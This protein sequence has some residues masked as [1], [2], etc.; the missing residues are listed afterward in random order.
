MSRVFGRKGGTAR[1]GVSEMPVDDRII[2][3]I[4]K[5]NGRSRIDGSLQ[6]ET[7]GGLERVERSLRKRRKKRAKGSTLEIAHRRNHID[8]DASPN[9][10]RSPVWQV[11]EATVTAIDTGSTT[12]A[13]TG[14]ND[15][16]PLA[17]EGQLEDFDRSVNEAVF[18]VDERT[19]SNSRGS[20]DTSANL[21]LSKIANPK[22]EIGTSPAFEGSNNK[23]LLPTDVASPNSSCQG[24][25]LI[26]VKEELSDDRLGSN[27]R[28]LLVPVS[29]NLYVLKSIRE[30]PRIDG[31]VTKLSGD[32]VNGTSATLFKAHI[33]HEV[34]DAGR[35]YLPD[36]NANYLYPTPHLRVPE[37]TENPMGH[38]ASYPVFLYPGVAF[39]TRANSIGTTPETSDGQVVSPLPDYANVSLV[40][41]NSRGGVNS[42]DSS[43]LLPSSFIPNYEVSPRG[44]ADDD[45]QPGT[46]SAK[47]DEV[48]LLQRDSGDHEDSSSEFGIE[49]T[50]ADFRDIFGVPDDNVYT[51]ATFETKYLTGDGEAFDVSGN[52]GDDFKFSTAG[53]EDAPVTGF[54]DNIS[55]RY[56]AASDANGGGTLL[57]NVA[58][59]SDTENVPNGEDKDSRECG[60]S[61]SGEYKTSTY[62]GDFDY[63][64]K[65]ISEASLRNTTDVDSF[66]GEDYVT[67]AS[68]LPSTDERPLKKAQSDVENSRVLLMAIK[69]L[70]S[71]LQKLLSAVKLVNR[72]LG[73]VQ[74]RLCDKKNVV[75]A[76]R[77]S[78]A[79]NITGL[80]NRVDRYDSDLF[81]ESFD[82]QPLDERRVKTEDGSVAE[83]DMKIRRRINGLFLN[84]L[85]TPF[86]KR[87]S[88]AEVQDDRGK[89]LKKRKLN[90][91]ES[92][93]SGNVERRGLPH[94]R[95]NRNPKSVTKNDEVRVKP[96]QRLIAGLKRTKR[97][98]TSIIRSSRL[99]ESS[100]SSEN[101]FAGGRERSRRRNNQTGR[102]IISS[103]STPSDI[104]MN[105]NSA[106]RFLSDRRDLQRDVKSSEM[107]GSDKEKKTPPIDKQ[108]RKEETAYA[109][110]L[111]LLSK[112]E[113][114]HVEYATDMW[115][116]E[117]VTESLPSL[118]FTTTESLSALTFLPYFAEES[119]TT[120]AER[121]EA[122][123]TTAVTGIPLRI[124]TTENFT[125]ESAILLTPFLEG[126]TDITLKIEIP[127]A[128]ETSVEETPV[129]IKTE[130][131]EETVESTSTEIMESL[132]VETNTSLYTSSTVSLFKTIGAELT[133]ETTSP[134]PPAVPV[135]T[136]LTTDFRTATS[137]STLGGT[138]YN[139]TAIASSPTVSERMEAISSTTEMAITTLTPEDE[140]PVTQIEKTITAEETATEIPTTI[141]TAT[142]EI[143]IS[144]S[145]TSATV[146]RI[147]TSVEATITEILT[148]NK[149]LTTAG[150]PTSIETPTVSEI[151]TII[152]TTTITST[153][154]ILTAFKTPLTKETTSIKETTSK[155]LTPTEILTS[156]KFKTTTETT[157]ISTPIK[158]TTITGILAIDKTL[159]TTEIP[160]SI[161]T[162][163]TSKIPMTSTVLTTVETT[164]KTLIPAEML[165]TLKT[166][167]TKETTSAK[168]LTPTEI[169]TSAKIETT[170][171]TSITTG[172]ST[173][174]ETTAI[175]E[176]LTI[177]PTTTG[178]SAFTEISITSEIPMISTTITE[179]ARI[180]ETSTLAEISATT[181]I[182]T[183]TKI[184]SSKALTP[185][186]METTS[187]TV[188]QTITKI[189]TT[190]EVSGT[191]EIPTI[192]T[193]YITTKF[194]TTSESTMMFSK[195][196]FPIQTAF[197]TNITTETT[198]SILITSTPV[199]TSV[200]TTIPTLKLTT[201]TPLITNTTL[202]ETPY[203]TISST[204]STTTERSVK[205]T[206][207]KTVIPS[208]KITTTT[209]LSPVTSTM[210]SETPSTAFSTLLTEETIASSIPTTSS[211]ETFPTTAALPISTTE[212]TV[213]TPLTTSSTI[214]LPITEET[215]LSEKIV[216]VTPSTIEGISTLSEVISISTGTTSAIETSDLIPI[217]AVTT[218]SLLEEITETSRVTTTERPEYATILEAAVT[219]T[220]APFSESILSILITSGTP[221]TT[222]EVISALP[223]TVSEEFTPATESPSVTY[224]TKSPTTLFIETT[225]QSAASISVFTEETPEVETEYYIAEEPFYEYE[226]YEE[227]EGYDT[228]IPT[229]KWYYYDEYETT[230]MKRTILPEQ[231][232]T[233]PFFIQSTTSSYEIE[234]SEFTRYSTPSEII[235]TYT[236]I[237]ST[238]A[239]S[240]LPYTEEE[241]TSASQTSTVI[242]NV[243]MKTEFPAASKTTESTARLTFG[244]TEEY[245]L[246]SSTT[247]K[248]PTEPLEN[249]TIPPKQRFTQTWPK[250][251]SP[252]FTT[253]QPEKI[254]EILE[255]TTISEGVSTET[256]VTK[257]TSFFVSPALTTLTQKEVFEVYTASTASSGTEGTVETGY[258]VS[259]LA[260][261]EEATI[262][263]VTP[264]IMSEAETELIFTTSKTVEREREELLQ[265]LADLEEHERKLAEREERLD[266]RE[267]QWSIEKEKR[268]KLIQ[269]EKEKAKNATATGTTEGYTTAIA[270]FVTSPVVSTENL[271]ASIT[272]IEV[273]S[274]GLGITAEI[275]T[276]P[277]ETTFVT[278]VTERTEEATGSASMKYTEETEEAVI[279]YTTEKSTEETKEAQI[280]DYGTLTSYVTTPIMD[281]YSSASIETVTP[282]TIEEMYTTSHVT[283][284]S[285]PLFT[286]PAITSA[287]E[288]FITLPVATFSERF[289]EA[290]TA[291]TP[292]RYT[293][294]ET[295]ADIY[296]KPSF[297]LPTLEFISTTTSATLAIVTTAEVRY[298]EEIERLREE[299]RKKE[300]EL[301]ER[302]KILLEREERLERDIMEFERYVEEFERKKTLVTS[303]RSTVLTSSSTPVSPTE[304]TTV[305]ARL[306]TQIKGVTEKKEYRTTT[307]IVSSRQTEMEDIEENKRTKYVPEETV[308]QIK[309]EIA[310][311]RMCLNI[312][313][314]ATIPLDKRR[315][316][317][318]KKICLPYFPEKH[319]E[320]ESVGRLSRRLLSLQSAGKVR[321]P[322]WNVPLGVRRKVKETTRKITNLQLSRHEWLSNEITKPPRHFQGFTRIY[323][324]MR[325]F[326]KK[327]STVTRKNGTS[328]F[329]NKTSPY[330]QRALDHHENIF[331]PTATSTLDAEEHRKRNAFFRY[332]LI[333]SRKNNLPIDN[334]GNVRKRDVSRIENDAR[335][336][337]RKSTVNTSSRRP[338]KIAK[339]EK[340]G[341]YTVNVLHL[342]YNEDEQVHE[343]ISAKPDE[344]EPA[345]ILEDDEV[346][347]MGK[348]VEKNEDYI[349]DMMDSTIKRILIFQPS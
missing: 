79:A 32:R 195:E 182:P 198:E 313:E 12:I 165:T 211:L 19:Y 83:A 254:P 33:H 137:E 229:D 258:E 224:A 270:V 169:L 46:V 40:D 110:I 85:T 15:R 196:F 176:I 280:T 321:G 103:N 113:K 310:T 166:P 272:E 322:G 29:K 277:T 48:S 93:E 281:L 75:R 88:S 101:N 257:L 317:V 337:S 183:T 314:N 318:T 168:T 136:T 217:I 289:E 16:P 51:P 49:W 154:G 28:F 242:E 286:S 139:A 243:T 116:T 288:K 159:T 56:G 124:P 62:S 31:M 63:D 100:V 240:G 8:E 150:P 220:L 43:A 58:Y 27:E 269:Y 87:E 297:T 181:K 225:T 104:F 274:P 332:D 348:K 315:D 35:V 36:R 70:S 263:H 248:I 208:S 299:V 301:E 329:Q 335:F 121:K 334:R 307:K 20:F 331:Q 135:S 163:T 172:I 21:I 193:T 126:M 3:T 333:S 328:K 223:K 105:D 236:N 111:Q 323:R 349:E 293:T 282:S 45:G 37:E 120:V 336:F 275:A 312:L 123:E 238:E 41:I 342:N 98:T 161:E 86:R 339:D 309:E 326:P 112:T 173:S 261:I 305:K 72:S 302:E 5:R 199:T 303:E 294:E 226:E 292:S 117:N 122:P 171:G 244:S 306:T 134:I 213:G 64:N 175:V 232:A 284:Y 264:F 311:K 296:S 77:E 53:N 209:S 212:S 283:L 343:V 206:S 91:R 141:E 1:S 69:P 233:S 227:Y 300:H 170:T 107:S 108:S 22:F 109:D 54:T 259:T 90:E 146:T 151:P 76:E 252:K 228:E 132:F 67:T 237:T 189:P 222:P 234:T 203:T 205:T 140:S 74:N 255:K 202:S 71:D 6:S 219:V 253:K 164:T 262:P 308:A 235:L 210:L 95:F 186:I 338:T 324:K 260:T 153:P 106:F 207:F 9:A 82:S 184:T 250:V 162:S 144:T 145:E 78:K 142:P 119:T 271:T 285:E 327:I 340:D 57:P 52:L 185:T 204:F 24:D 291:S 247:F 55:T 99:I 273:T 17:F 39:R 187:T 61:T 347:E 160:T 192:S 152:E 149:T 80:I 118:I 295:Y 267:R 304:K 96:V 179:T 180:S 25:S 298:D 143:A 44:D 246:P 218:A 221:A 268:R 155:T 38:L 279:S 157:E 191:T 68:L 125:T 241:I 341:F 174:A 42:H 197:T 26:N 177:T 344:D 215:S 201:A 214:T 102:S 158:I 129:L 50:T 97:T 147:S 127:A 249:L 115:T 345:V 34:E 60:I 138:L 256:E 194:S 231:K 66:L 325:K 276:V 18:P 131:E 13:E 290:S 11:L 251:T 190:I 287:T 319:E 133:I 245:T 230:T 156:I 239:T 23:M 59:S 94:S 167:I 47:L 2:Q 148:I 92:P 10:M 65:S 89:F 81:T 84:R 30:S 278:Y 128:T 266:E 346:T 4:N 14:V 188:I 265:R 114:S 216:T 320:K 200:K 330:E 73:N 178:T 316:I 7:N 130:T